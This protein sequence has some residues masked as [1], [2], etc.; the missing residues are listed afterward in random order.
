[1]QNHHCKTNIGTKLI[2]I[3]H[4]QNSLILIRGSSFDE[5]RSIFDWIL[6]WNPI[7]TPGKSR[8]KSNNDDRK[9]KKEDRIK[10]SQM[11]RFK[12]IVQRF[13]QLWEKVT[14]LGKKGQ[15]PLLELERYKKNSSNLAGDVHEAHL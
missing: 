12:S 14:S 11:W 5:E 10:E 6:A 7:N 1:L 8:Q 4:T 13:P 15:H 9:N 2:A 3:K